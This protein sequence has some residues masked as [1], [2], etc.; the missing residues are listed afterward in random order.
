MASN[1]YEKV[2]AQEEDGTLKEA[3][4]AYPWIYCPGSNNKD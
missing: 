2:S 3:E 1:K 4:N